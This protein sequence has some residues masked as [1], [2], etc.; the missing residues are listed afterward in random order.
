[1]TAAPNWEEF[2]SRSFSFVLQQKL[3]I[4]YDSAPEIETERRKRKAI[5][6]VHDV[7]AVELVGRDVWHSLTNL[8]NSQTLSS[9]LDCKLTFSL[10]DNTRNVL[11]GIYNDQNCGNQVLCSELGYICAGILANYRQLPSDTDSEDCWHSV[12]D[13]LITIPLKTISSCRGIE[14]HIGRNIT[15]NTGTTKQHLRPDFLV[16]LEDHLLVLKGEHKNG[17]TSMQASIDELKSKMSPGWSVLTYGALDYII[18]FATAGSFIRFFSI[19]KSHELIPISRKF[20]VRKIED[21]AS[22]FKIVVN[23]VRVI[24][25]MANYWP[26]KWSNISVQAYRSISRGYYVV[27]EFGGCDLVKKTSGV[28][29]EDIERLREIHECLMD[30]PGDASNLHMVR[31]YDLKVYP[32]AINA[33][34][35]PLGFQ[36]VP[37]DA[38]ELLMAIYSVLLA[39]RTWHSCGWCHGDIRWSN[40]VYVP[41]TVEN[42]FWMLIDFDHSRK[43]ETTYVNW[44]HHPARSLG[45]KLIPLHDLMQVG[46]LISDRLQAIAHTPEIL[47]LSQKLCR[48]EILTTDDALKQSVFQSAGFV[49]FQ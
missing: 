44:N 41:V 6:L 11:P 1:M 42:G 25:V 39:L 47:H 26:P 30:I 15:D 19:T 49:D 5:A 4:W 18:C 40:I 33:R 2:V 13:D 43:P 23:L 27:L 17:S 46:N 3:R 8:P 38:R 28:S 20:N 21:C 36:T 12:Y 35:G 9:V 22:V 45:Q 32:T 16:T 7:P 34:L 24:E 29:T 10:G 48:G 14:I 37:K 31:V